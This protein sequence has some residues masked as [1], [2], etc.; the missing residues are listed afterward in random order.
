MTTLPRRTLALLLGM[1]LIAFVGA[2][3]ASAAKKAPPNTGGNV[4]STVTGTF[5]DALGG[6]GT[7]TGSFTPTAFSAQDGQLM[8]TGALTTAL[9]DSAGEL[10]GT[11][12]ETIT[13]A[14]QQATGS[15]EILNLVLGPLNLDLLGL[16]VFLD[17]VTLIITA[18]PGPGNLLGN[19]LC[20]VAGLLNGPTGLNAL[21]G[22][23]A[24][25]L[26]QI[27]GLLG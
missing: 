11:A 7:V 3:S 16:N 1:T 6:V 15:C 5:D 24:N 4:T 14:V 17:T 9:V 25:L 27:L 2:G 19:L 8:A 10:V 23:I 12:T 26:N 20:A 22:Q 13:T 18:E 21:V